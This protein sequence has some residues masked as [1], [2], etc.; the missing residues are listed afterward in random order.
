MIC[1]EL[2]VE[3]FH[4]YL[5]EIEFLMNYSLLFKTNELWSAA[6]KLKDTVDAVLV[7]S[8]KQTK[9]KSVQLRKTIFFV[10]IKVNAKQKWNRL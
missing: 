10:E 4:Y 3:I 8:N 6:Q 1:F 5:F 2:G 9:V 7:I